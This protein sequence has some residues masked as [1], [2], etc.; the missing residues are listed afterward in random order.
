MG[1]GATIPWSCLPGSQE[2]HT[3]A[4][5]PGRFLLSALAKPLEPDKVLVGGLPVPPAQ[6]G[7][8]YMYL[9]ISAG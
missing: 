1:G 8:M 7:Y 5:T 6:C 4:N 9:W 3:L 2:Q